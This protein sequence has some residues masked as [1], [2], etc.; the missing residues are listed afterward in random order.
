M[1][2][3]TI[4]RGS[5]YEQVLVADDYDD[6][7]PHITDAVVEAQLHIAR[8]GGDRTVTITLTHANAASSRQAPG[9]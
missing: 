8:N 1:I 4:T 7:A 6:I 2:V 9:R 3:C 5:G